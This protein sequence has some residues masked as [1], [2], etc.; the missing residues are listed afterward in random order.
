M[1][2]ARGVEGR[3]CTT[4]LRAACRGGVSRVLVRQPAANPA[5]A[6]RARF[7]LLSGHRHFAPDTPMLPY[8]MTAQ[9]RQA[10]IEES[11]RLIALR[12]AKNAERAQAANDDVA[13]SE[14]PSAFARLVSDLESVP[15]RFG[16]S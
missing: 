3:R 2:Q 12:A 10:V 9:T 1:L 4:P 6:R 5:D 13:A 14:S 7:P 16:R 11:N 15:A 8:Y